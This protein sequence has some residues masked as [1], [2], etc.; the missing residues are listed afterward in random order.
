M[1]VMKR[2]CTG[3]KRQR[4]S[5]EIGVVKKKDGEKRREEKRK[6]ENHMGNINCTKRQ[7][8]PLTSLISGNVDWGILRGVGALIWHPVDSLHLERVLR[9]GQQVTNVDP[10]FCQAQLTGQKLNVVPAA[11]AAS[12]ASTTALADDVED[13]ILTAPWVPRRHP[14]QHHRGF[15]HAGDDILWSW[16]DSWKTRQPFY[17]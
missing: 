9:V 16:R 6:R 8:G 15:V 1:R 2:Y 13:Y 11:G 17:G 7:M 5:T 12:P 4:S 14:L 10:G 3:H